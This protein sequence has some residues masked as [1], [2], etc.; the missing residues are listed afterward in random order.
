ME[1]QNIVGEFRFPVRS[2]RL[3]LTTPHSLRSSPIR[4]EVHCH[5][6]AINRQITCCPCMFQLTV[7]ELGEIVVY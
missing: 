4:G 1:N 3:V 2:V 5:E 6:Q 7:K